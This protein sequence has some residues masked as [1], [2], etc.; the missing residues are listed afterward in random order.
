MY[1]T[2]FPPPGANECSSSST[3]SSPDGLQDIKQAMVTPAVA[4]DRTSDEASVRFSGSEDRAAIA[5]YVL[6]E[7]RLKK[8]IES[9]HC[10][11]EVARFKANSQSGSHIGG[12]SRLASPAPSSRNRGSIRQEPIS[13]TEQ[14]DA[15]GV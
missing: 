5:T 10:Q 6:K 13:P 3:Q 9:L 2:G 1:T 7:A 14:N 15:N 4:V 8:R 11:K 12:Q